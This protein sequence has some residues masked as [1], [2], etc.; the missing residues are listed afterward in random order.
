METIKGLIIKLA[1]LIALVSVILFALGNT[2]II[3]V[4]FF[5]FELQAP[6]AVWVVSAFVVGGVSGLLASTG[7]MLSHKRKT[8]I[9]TGSIKRKDKEIA[10]LRS[11]VSRD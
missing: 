3:E 4:S 7:M 6:V 2:Q 10:R 11:V 5:F 9:H 1:I 8:V